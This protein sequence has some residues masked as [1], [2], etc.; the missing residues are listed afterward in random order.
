MRRGTGSECND[1]LFDHL[2]VCFEIATGLHICQSAVESLD[3]AFVLFAL[4]FDDLLFNF[5]IG[6]KY[7]FGTAHI[8]M[9]KIFS[10]IDLPNS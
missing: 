1:G 5:V 9:E 3:L 8:H 2:M 10:K 6:G 7:A 4:L